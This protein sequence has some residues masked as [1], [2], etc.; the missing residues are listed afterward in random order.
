[1]KPN[2]NEIRKSLYVIKKPQNRS[3]SK[4]KNIE[5]NHLE[6][7]NNL[8]RLKDYHDYDDIE[9][10][11]IRDVGN[12]FDQSEDY[13][14]PIKTTGVF[15]NK[16]NYIEYESN[17]DKDKIFSVKE[18]LDLIRPYLS[19]MINDHKT[20]GELKVHSGNQGEWKIQLS[21]T[22]NFISSKDSN[23]IR[24]MHR[25][26]NNIRIMMGSETDEIII[27]LFECLLQRYQEGL[28][29]NMRGSEFVFDSVD[30]LYYRL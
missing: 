6:L 1:M 15:D 23:E 12:L 5:E 17:V 20:H 18:Y 9:Y 14:K 8:S 21:M 24:S 2:T 29:E 22:I 13:Y 3:K 28:E 16:N 19:D 25:K 4:I 30:L 26:S 7:E 11:G 10:R 27:E